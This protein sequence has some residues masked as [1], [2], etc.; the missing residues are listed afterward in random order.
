MPPLPPTP[1]LPLTGSH[2]RTGQYRLITTLLALDSAP[3]VN[4]TALPLTLRG[5]A[6]SQWCGCGSG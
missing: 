5:V 1:P 4:P 2:S 6:P 3:T